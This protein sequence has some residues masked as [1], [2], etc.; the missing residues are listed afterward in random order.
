M[1]C[2]FLLCGEYVPRMWAFDFTR[3]WFGEC[4]I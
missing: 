3:S 4:Y 1:A 2:A